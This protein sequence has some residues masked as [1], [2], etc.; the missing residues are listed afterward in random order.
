[1]HHHL[2][3]N[4]SASSR[5]K[6]SIQLKKN[7]TTRTNMR[8]LILAVYEIGKTIL[9]TLICACPNLILNKIKRASKSNSNFLIISVTYYEHNDVN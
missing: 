5:S 3:S 9:V 6:A 7:I 4:V 2:F 8:K 1:M